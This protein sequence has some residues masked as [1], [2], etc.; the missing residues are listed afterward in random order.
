MKV[1]LQPSQDIMAGGWRNIYKQAATWKE[2]VFQRTL[3]NSLAKSRSGFQR[4]I[5]ES[6]RDQYRLHSCRK[7][8]V[9]PNKD[10]AF[11]LRGVTLFGDV[12]PK[13]RRT[14]ILPSFLVQPRI[15]ACQ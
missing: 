12:G 6:L 11:R 5:I 8:S 10:S 1:E 3:S 2:K 15:P 4:G 7:R 9:L 14:T 13:T